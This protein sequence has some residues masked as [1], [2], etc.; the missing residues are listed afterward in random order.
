MPGADGIRYGNEWVS[1]DTPTLRIEVAADGLYGLSLTDLQAN[2]FSYDPTA[3]Y[4]LILRGEKVPL[5]RRSD[6]LYFYG[7]RNRA[8]LDNYLYANPEDHLLNPQYSLY[9]D[10]AVYYLRSSVEPTLDFSELTPDLTNL[11]APESSISRTHLEVFAAGH[12]KEF[13][14]QAGY[15]IYYSRY[16]RAEGYGSRTERDLLRTDG[17]TLSAFDFVLPQVQPGSEAQLKL[18]LGLGFDSHEQLISLNGENLETINS[19]GWG[20]FQRTYTFSPQTEEQALRLNGQAG[21]RDKANLAYLKVDYQAT[22]DAAGASLLNFQLAASSE[23]RYLEITNYGGNDPVVYDLDQRLFINAALS[24]TTVQLL[25][26][27]GPSDRRLILME[28]QG[29]APVAKLAMMDWLPATASSSYDY[30]LLT[31]RQLASPSDL[32]NFMTY[33]QSPAGGGHRL[34][35]AYVED[36]YEQFGYG[37]QRH[38][39]AIRNFIAHEI[40]NNSELEFLFLLGKGRELRNLR[41][42]E[43]LALNGAEHY[44]PAFG[45]P[46]S[47]LLLSSNIGQMRPQLATGR[48]AIFDIE[49]LEPYLQKLIAIEAQRDNPQNINDRSWMKRILHLG[50]GTDAGDRQSIRNQ[51]SSMERVVDTTFFAPQVTTYYK[52]T[53]DPTET[54]NRS[55][56]FQDINDGLSILSFFGHSSGQVFDFD[57]DRPE[58]YANAGKCPII[59]SFGCY[60]GDMYTA[61]KS[62]GERFVLMPENGA[63]AFGATQGVGFVGALGEFGRELYRR[64]GTD[65]YGEGLGQII[66]AT[67]GAFEGSGNYTMVTMLEQY[68][69][70]GDPAYRIHPQ[71]GA[72]LLVNSATVGFDPRVISLQADSFQVE[73]ELFNLGS[74]LEE[75]SLTL[76]FEQ[77]LPDGSLRDLGQR[78]VAAPIYS[79]ALNFSFPNGDER[80]VGANRLRITVDPENQLLERP[81]PAAQLNNRTV[82]GNGQEGIP[83]FIVA[84]SAQPVEPPRYGLTSGSTITL[85]AV[86]SDAL[87]EERDWVFQLATT[88]DFAEVL[89][90]GRQRSGG[91]LLRWTPSITWID[92][93]VYYWRV[94]PDSSQL[95]TQ[96]PAWLESSFTYLQNTSSGWG[97]GHYDQFGDGQTDLLVNL[98]PDGFEFRADSLDV[99]VFG[100]VNYIN[101]TRPGLSI[102]DAIGSSEFNLTS[103]VREGIGAFVMEPYT[104]RLWSNP[105]D[106]RFAAGDYG[107]PTGSKTMFCFW[108]RTAEERENFL[109]FLDEVVPEDYVVYLTTLRR[110]VDDIHYSSEWAMD[111]TIYGRNIYSYLEAQGALQI[112]ELEGNDKFP[113]VYAYRKGSGY[114]GEAIGDSDEDQVQIR[115]PYPQR[116]VEGSLQSPVFGPALSWEEL[117]WRVADLDNPLDDNRITLLG[118]NSPAQ[119]DSIM[120]IADIG[121]FDL[122]QIDATE[123][124]YLQFRWTV[125][126]PDPTLRTAADLD[127]LHL[128]GQPAPDLLFNAAAY[129]QRSADTLAAGEQYNF[130]IAIQNASA[131]PT[132]SVEVRSSWLGNN[133]VLSSQT[134]R[135]RALVED[136][137]LRYELSLNTADFQQAEVLRISINPSRNQLETNYA[138]NEL[139]RSFDLEIDRIDPLINVTFDGRPIRDGALVSARPAILVE[140]TDENRFLLLDRPDQFGLQLRLPDGTVQ[141]IDP[142][143]GD[144]VQFEPAT[145]G[146]Q[147][148]A[149]LLFSPDLPQDGTYSLLVQGADASGNSAGRLNYEVDFEVIREQSISQVVNYPNPFSDLTYFVYELTGQEN[150]MDYRIQIMTVSGR[151]VREL[152]GMELGPLRVGRHQTDFGWDGTDSFGDQLANGIYLYRLVLPQESALN[153]PAKVRATALDEFYTN[154]IGKLVIL[155]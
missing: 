17:T 35:I 83:F 46:A 100:E 125:T 30:L 48:L 149:R 99:G 132:D 154:G 14:R 73:L 110:S 151:V 64:I 38:P 7:Q 124:P 18:R 112:R 20:V 142:T 57:I 33:R 84:T 150:L 19:I 32:S 135:F 25:L 106:D 72:D 43:D 16:E 119:L 53:S 107:V 80:S 34:H 111:S 8:E 50:G 74:K 148:Q 3:D 5:Q 12:S 146:G 105:P 55:E 66:Q 130:G 143:N 89:E 4:E 51:L 40:A 91:G 39:Q 103:F 44:L 21:T 120:G 36:L 128:Q 126:D 75:D 123:Y 127:F 116:Y 82:D 9:S 134:D 24:G 98:G 131:T 78:R 31:S 118:G 23:E 22:P 63:V 27:A 117:S 1:F 68:A 129:H 96:R 90:E 136:D 11:P 13:R 59:F 93:T 114:L 153:D 102:N 101:A 108:L 115:I 141:L 10:T 26:P 71:R 49:E 56:I 109:T 81:S 6:G 138:N 60:S 67:V 37:I 113:Y 2:G 58:N 137:T 54:V 41:T 62:I 29:A 47:D 121:A 139:E 77:Q 69:L 122:S 133:E 45:Y 97:Q 65:N 61:T 87:A 144:L 28:R 85:K 152:S 76:G 104:G 92:S 15:S 88:A 140:I 155:R 70:Q 94:S 95:E 86:T 145:E 52:T 42:T 147:N 79:S